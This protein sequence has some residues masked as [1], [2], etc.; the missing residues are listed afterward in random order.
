MVDNGPGIPDAIFK[1]LFQKVQSTKS[2]EHGGLGLSIVQSLV[3]E[4]NGKISCRTMGKKGTI[5]HILLPKDIQP[6]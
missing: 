6:E 2:G 1:Q 5:F 3:K 4:M